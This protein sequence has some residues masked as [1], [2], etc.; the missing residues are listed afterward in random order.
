MQPGLLQHAR[1]RHASHRRACGRTR[2]RRRVERLMRHWPATHMLL[3]ELFARAQVVQGQVQARQSHTRAHGREAVSVSVS[4]LR[5]GLRPLRE[6]QDSQANSHGSLSQ[7]FLL[8]FF[9]M[10]FRF[11]P[12]KT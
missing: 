1:H 5:Q 4:R 9:L 2:M 7:L 8:L 10:L 12:I 11:Y 6:P 3:G